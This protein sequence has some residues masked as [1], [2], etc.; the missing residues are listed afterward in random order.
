MIGAIRIER[1]K[2]MKGVIKEYIDCGLSRR[3]FISALTGLGLTAAAARTVA[4]DFT[5][6]VT[7]PGESPPRNAG[8][9]ENDTRQW[10]QPAG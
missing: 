5:P 2:K 9:G 7:R 10:R 6:F 1:E 8:L 3:Q 4:Q